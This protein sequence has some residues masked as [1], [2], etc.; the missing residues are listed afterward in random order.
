MT[1]TLKDYEAYLEKLRSFKDLAWVKNYLKMRVKPN[2]WT[3]IEYGK[4]E[5]S[6]DRSAHETRMSKMLRWMMDPNENHR[7]G[8]IFSYEILRLI[9]ADYNYISNGSKKIKALAEYED[10]DVFYTDLDQGLC[11]AIE[12]KQHAKEGQTS[13]GISQLD[14]YQKITD[15]LSKD[16]GLRAYYVF[17]T[18]LGSLPSNKKWKSVSYSDLIEI[19]NK[20]DKDYIIKST[21]PYKEDTR[22]II[23]DF[24]DELQRTLDLYEKDNYYISKNLTD[25][26]KNLTFTLAKE[27]REDLESDHMDILLSL[28][29][30]EDFKIRELILLA[31]DH[32]YVQNSSPNDEIRI[33]T[34]KIYN[35]FSED[36]ELDTVRLRTYSDKETTSRI[37]PHLVKSMAI[38]FTKIEL[39]RGKGQ[40]LNFYTEDFKYRVY[41]SGDSYGKFP[42]DGVQLLNNPKDKAKIDSELLRAR[43]FQIRDGLIL[44]DKIQDTRGNILNLNDFI[45]DH[46]A[47]AL[48]ELGKKKANL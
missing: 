47:P 25:K 34:R 5:S 20:V 8:N 10:I 43:T 28:N 35:Y 45:E 3:I 26:E 48:R 31:D 14:K 7:L 22:K 24:R 18:P 2:F 30:L 27:I 16:K 13:Q 4:Y 36:K 37:K 23:L 38:D 40:G 15:D 44:E 42:N 32:L 33:L 21:S 46:L 39:T 17:L 29:K 1:Y 41:M 19:I 12:V 9:G 11:L 6:N